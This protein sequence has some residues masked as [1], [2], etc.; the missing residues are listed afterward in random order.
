MTKMTMNISHVQVSVT[1][2]V[3]DPLMMSECN[4]S[5][6]SLTLMVS[7]NDLLADLNL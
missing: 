7:Q 3:P 2:D 6:V 1:T 4:I 5:Q